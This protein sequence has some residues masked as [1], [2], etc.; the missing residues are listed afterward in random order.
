[1]RGS[2]TRDRIRVENDEGDREP[3]E[4]RREV[5]RIE[6]RQ[7]P[8]LF[9]GVACG[10]GRRDERWDSCDHGRLLARQRVTAISRTG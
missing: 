6:L 4:L 7:T 3:D 8:S 1:M 2:A 9:L 10:G 5:V